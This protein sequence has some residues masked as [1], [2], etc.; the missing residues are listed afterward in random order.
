MKR[1][2]VIVI[3]VYILLGILGLLTVLVL[4]LTAGWLPVSPDQYYEKDSRFYRALI[5]MAAAVACWGGGVRLHVTGRELLP[6]ERRILYVGNHVSN[7]DPIVTWHAFPEA[8]LS[9]ISKAANFKLPWLGRFVRRC[10]FMDIDRENPRNAIHTINRAAELLKRQ[11]VSV[12]V[13]PEGT[14]S[15]TGQLLPFH[16][17][18]FKVAQKAEADMAVV[19]VIG[20][21]KV[22]KN[23]PFHRTDVYLDVL[24]VI[25]SAELHKTKTEVIGARVAELLLQ[26]KAKREG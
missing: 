12:G 6:K 17:G 21:E 4:F 3:I 16:N 11:E 13:Y 20:T 19:S 24:E 25:P 8:K 1:A 10:C 22:V 2:G 14:R 5:N 9:F 7:Y 23:Y 18:V 15:K 26:N